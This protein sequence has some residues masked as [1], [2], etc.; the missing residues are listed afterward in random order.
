[1]QVERLKNWIAIE[2]GVLLVICFAIIEWDAIKVSV[3]I[4]ACRTRAQ[5]HVCS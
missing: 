4:V 2:C 3:T 1:M 5:M